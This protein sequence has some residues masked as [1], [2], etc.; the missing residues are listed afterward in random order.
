MFYRLSPRS[1]F[2]RAMDVLVRE[3]RRRVEQG[4]FEFTVRC[5]H[6]DVGEW[7]YLTIGEQCFEIPIWSPPRMDND[8]DDFEP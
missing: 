2:D 6:D 7:A 5:N 1:E 4:P 3:I 8:W